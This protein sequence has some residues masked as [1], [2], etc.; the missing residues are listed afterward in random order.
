M[1]HGDRK[2]HRTLVAGRETGSSPANTALVF[3]V[4]AIE[5]QVASARI[6]YTGR[7]V[8]TRTPFSEQ[9]VVNQRSA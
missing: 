9:T 7:S 4:W 5:R 2:M 8:K 6:Y 3:L 1:H